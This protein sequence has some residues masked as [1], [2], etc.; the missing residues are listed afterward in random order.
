VNKHC[1]VNF[2]F[3]LVWTSL[4]LSKLEVYT[5]LDNKATDQTEFAYLILSP[6][7][8]KTHYSSFAIAQIW[9]WKVQS[10]SIWFWQVQSIFISHN[11]HVRKEYESHHP[12]QDLATLDDTTTTR[13]SIGKNST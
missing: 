6:K 7:Y 2:K 5:I 13:G 8:V 10:T 9:F 1:W 4:L 11:F 12:K 3:T